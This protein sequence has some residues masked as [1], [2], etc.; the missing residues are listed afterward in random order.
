LKANGRI[1]PRRTVRPLLPAEFGSHVEK[2]RRHKFDDA[3]RQRCGDAL[4]LPDKPVSNFIP[5]E[6]DETEPIQMPSDDDPVDSEGRAVGEQSV[7]DRLLHAELTLPHGESRQYAKVLSRARDESGNLIGTYDDNPLLNTMLYD[8]EFADGAV[9]QYTANIIAKNMY[10]QVDS[11]GRQY[12]ILDSI[13]D[14]SK[15]GVE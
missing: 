5:Y 7:F 9:K 15:D 13:I 3:I 10:S 14:Y 12:N 8:V 4:S 6:D 2:E 11:E 1:V